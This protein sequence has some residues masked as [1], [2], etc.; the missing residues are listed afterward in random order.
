MKKI[1]YKL[2]KKYWSLLSLEH[3]KKNDFTVKNGLFKNLKI[4]K[5]I[6]WGKADI[7]SKVYGL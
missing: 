5:D 7:A 1:L 6:S 2:T 3:A 4:N